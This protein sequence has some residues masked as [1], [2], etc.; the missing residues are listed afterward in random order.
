MPSPIVIFVFSVIVVVVVV[1][2]GCK[3][4]DNQ[5]TR[6]REPTL[7]YK[8]G[9][10]IIILHTCGHAIP[11]KKVRPY[12]ESISRAE[13]IASPHAAG[14]CWC[15]LRWNVLR[16]AEGS[17]LIVCRTLRDG[18]LSVY[19]FCGSMAWSCEVAFHKGTATR[20]RVFCLSS[21]GSIQY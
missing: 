14:C 18:D 10:N 6:A 4:C 5:P 8:A 21:S 12:R 15:L 7:S 13:H 11:R 2:I 3:F 20:G 9:D 1:C 17:S 19:G 16:V